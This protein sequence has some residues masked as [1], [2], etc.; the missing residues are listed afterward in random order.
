MVPVMVASVPRFT[1]H[2]GTLGI[3]TEVG[4]NLNLVGFPH[5]STQLFSLFQLLGVLRLQFS[6]GNK[7]FASHCSHWRCKIRNKS[8]QNLIDLS[9][10]RSCL[11]KRKNDS[12]R[13]LVLQSLPPQSG[14]YANFF[15]KSSQI[16][17]LHI[18]IPEDFHNQLQI[19]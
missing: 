3:C 18:E 19:F 12:T 11:V 10:T 5:C 15:N 13:A 16:S 2:A 17:P 14:K 7:V 8:A 6:L 1:H 4:G 9:F